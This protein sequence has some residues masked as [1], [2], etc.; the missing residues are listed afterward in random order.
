MLLKRILHHTSRVRRAIIITTHR[1][2]R[3]PHMRSL[4][5]INIDIIHQS[6][7]IAHRHHLSASSNINTSP[8]RLYDAPTLCTI[9][10]YI[11][12]P[13]FYTVFYIDISSLFHFDDMRHDTYTYSRIHEHCCDLH[14]VHNDGLSPERPMMSHIATRGPYCLGSISFYTACIL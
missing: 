1:I 10:F 12:K 2:Q 11:N 4:G 8:M 6:V 14:T 7:G 9:A 13:H 3:R 5:S